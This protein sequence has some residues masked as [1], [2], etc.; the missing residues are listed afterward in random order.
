MVKRLIPKNWVSLKTGNKYS[1]NEYSNHGYGGLSPINQY[2]WGAKRYL[3][4]PKD[5]YPFTVEFTTKID[6]DGGR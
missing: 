3:D 1:F 6:K 5:E 4:L 2:V